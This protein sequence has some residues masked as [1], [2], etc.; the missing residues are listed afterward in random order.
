[1]RPPSLCGAKRAFGGAS[2]EV[3]AP[4][5][6]PVPF[7]N[8][9]DNSLVIRI[10]LGDRAALLVGDAE[11]AEEQALLRGSSVRADF[12]KVG[13][14]G[15]ATSSSPAFLA[16]VGA[17]DAAISCGVRNRFGHPRAV[18][19]RALRERMRVHRTDEDGSIV[20]ETDGRSTAV[21]T[22]VGA[23]RS[24]EWRPWSIL[25]ARLF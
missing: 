19:L 1:L 7:A 23:E 6:E 3:L 9:N 24:R 8:P 13:H 20:W 15:S 10:S 12:L 17:E 4:C 22:A 21:E 14:H 18:T 16:A 25:P 5:P 11:R 2:V